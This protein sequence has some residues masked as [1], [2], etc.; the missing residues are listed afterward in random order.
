MSFTISC[1]ID[2]R[3]FYIDQK[4]FCFK[5]EEGCDST[6]FLKPTSKEEIGNIISS[7]NSNKASGPNSILYRILFH[8]SE[9]SVQLANLF[10][11]SFLTGPVFFHQ[12]SRLKVVPDFKKD[13]KLDFSNLSNAPVIKY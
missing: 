10:N 8:R 9:I 11:L 1:N 6:I 4:F 7:L 13:S 3:H 5:F 12:Y 2:C